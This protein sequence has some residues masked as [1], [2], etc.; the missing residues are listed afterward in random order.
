MQRCNALIRGDLDST[1]TFNV[2]GKLDVE[3]LIERSRDNAVLL[4]LH[5]TDVDLAVS[6]LDV[7]DRHVV[8]LLHD[9]LMLLHGLDV[10]HDLVEGLV[11]VFALLHESADTRFHVLCTLGAALCSKLVCLEPVGSLM[12][13]KSS[14]LKNAGFRRQR[15]AACA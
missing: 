7:V 8:P 10:M 2:G 4:E 13:E 9:L 6:L 12:T 11:V 3:V 15:A 1:A 5:A 14:R